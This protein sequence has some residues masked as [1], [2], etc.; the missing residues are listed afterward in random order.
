[1]KIVVHPKY[2]SNQSLIINMLSQFREE[3]KTVYKGRNIVKSFNTKYGE[4]IIKKY[5]NPNLIQRFIY[6]FFRKSKAERAFLYAEKLLSLGI[7]TPEAVAYIE[8]K[9]YGLLHK[10]YFISIA[11]ND[12]ALYPILVEK[13]EYDHR[14]VNSLAAFFVEM[15]QKGFLHGDPNLDN[16]LYRVDQQGNIKFTVIDTNR[17]VFKSHLT[18]QE[19]LNNL[20]RV[21]H[22][23]DLLQHI[24]Q[25]Y[26]S[27]RDWDP[28]K[29]IEQVMAALAKFERRRK[30]K[31]IIKRKL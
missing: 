26:A 1:M 29:S 10:S 11:C 4:W 27:I 18:P 15:H 19:C 31:H 13:R 8:E 7:N 9:E 3:G 30:I 25:E 28:E 16:I 14:I 21:T 5:K 17:S 23:R 24:T 22:R 2:K 12:L 20:K 6:S